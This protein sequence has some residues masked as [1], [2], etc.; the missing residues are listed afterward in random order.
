MYAEGVSPSACPCEVFIF[1]YDSWKMQ[2]R[3]HFYI[4]NVGISV[5]GA[6]AP[7]PPSGAASG[8]G[9]HGTEPPRSSL[10]A[11]EM[12][13]MAFSNGTRVVITEKIIDGTSVSLGWDGH[14][15]ARAYDVA[16]AAVPAAGSPGV[17]ADWAVQTV[18]GTSH[19]IDGLDPYSEYEIRVGVRGDPSTQSA[20]RAF[21]GG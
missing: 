12:F 14:G 6:A 9:G 10:S 1:T 18:G 3:K 13:A 8:M 19:R 15:G 7:P 5:A 20:V 11:G 16:V 17:G 21:T 4:D 2:I